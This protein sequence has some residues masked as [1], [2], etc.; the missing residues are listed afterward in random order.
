MRLLLVEDDE[1]IGE[2]IAEMMH[3]ADHVID[4]ARNG[5]EAKSLLDH[6]SYDLLLVVGPWQGSERLT[7]FRT[8]GSG[9]PSITMAYSSISCSRTAM[10]KSSRTEVCTPGCMPKSGKPSARAW[11]QSSGAPG[12]NR[13]YSRA[14]SR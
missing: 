5:P 7:F 6:E 12:M 10:W 1:M 9:T 3:G 11:R 13:G 14:S 4:W 2:P 8:F